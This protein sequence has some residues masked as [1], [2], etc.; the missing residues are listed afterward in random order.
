MNPRWT[1]WAWRAAKALLAVAILAGV[2]RQ[3]YR[4]LARPDNPDQAAWSELPLRPG[5]VVASA[6]LYLMGLACSA[7]Y[8]YRL[9]GI[10]G[11][12]PPFRQ[13]WRAYFIGQLGKYVPGKAWALLLRG[14]LVAGPDLRLGTAIITAFYEVLTTMATGALIAALIF[15]CARPRSR[16]WRGTLFIPAC[17]FLACAA[18]PCCRAYSII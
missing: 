5:W 9:L 14:G 6:C 18:Y 11:T 10:F 13:A 17:C 4:D 8:W 3:F 12:A 2:G 15:V 1:K 16:T 7:I